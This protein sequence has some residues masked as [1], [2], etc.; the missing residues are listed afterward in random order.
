MK[1]IFKDLNTTEKTLFFSSFFQGL[2]VETAYFVGITGY[3][4]YNLNATPSLIAIVMVF[5]NV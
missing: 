2:G 1:N 4:A 3:A 5:L